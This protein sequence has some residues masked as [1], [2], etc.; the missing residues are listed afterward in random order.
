MVKKE[1]SHIDDLKNLN[2]FRAEIIIKK[3][4]QEV[5]SVEYHNLNGTEVQLNEKEIDEILN[6]EQ[7]P[8]VNNIDE[9]IFSIMLDEGLFIFT[10]DNEIIDGYLLKESRY[11][12]IA[13]LDL[14]TQYLFK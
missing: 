10:I 4:G 1:S 3:N 5:E 9:N 11:S 14:K 6:W 2:D 13:L 7:N 8:K 12:K